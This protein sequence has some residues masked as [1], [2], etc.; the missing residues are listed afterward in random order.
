MILNN[1]IF[2]VFNGSWSERKKNEV[3]KILYKRNLQKTKNKCYSSSI[4][5]SMNTVDFILLIL[6]C[7]TNI[8]S[9]D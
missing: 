8:T 7:S 5:I 6:L 3:K 1:I 4:T 2:M 9:K